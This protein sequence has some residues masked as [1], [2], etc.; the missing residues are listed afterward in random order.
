MKSKCLSDCGQ[1]IMSPQMQLSVGLITEAGNDISE[2]YP[3]I[4]LSK[5]ASL[6]ITSKESLYIIIL[7]IL[8]V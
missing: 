1:L 2:M 4:E 7:A 8:D 5:V 6:T 3:N